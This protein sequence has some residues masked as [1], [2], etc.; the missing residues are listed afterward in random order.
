MPCAAMRP[1]GPIAVPGG[2]AHRLTLFDQEQFM[3]QKQAY[4]LAEC[5]GGMPSSA[6]ATVWVDS[7]FS[8]LATR[9]RMQY[10][11]AAS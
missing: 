1:I 11:C 6:R 3:H 9:L 2:R 8:N 10:T 5:M 7:V 4:R